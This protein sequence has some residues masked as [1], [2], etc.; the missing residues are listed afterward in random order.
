MYAGLYAETS[1][2]GLRDYAVAA[3]GLAGLVVDDAWW[4]G[5]LRNLRTILIQADLIKNKT[6]SGASPDGR[7]GGTLPVRTRSRWQM[8]SGRAGPPPWPEPRRHWTP[9]PRATR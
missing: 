4:P 6:G 2:E 1:E 5:V 8:T 9:S 7:A 3:A